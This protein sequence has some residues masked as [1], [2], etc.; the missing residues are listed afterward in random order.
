LVAALAGSVHA[1]VF[2]VAQD[3]RARVIDGERVLDMKSPA[4][5]CRAGLCVHGVGG[6]LMLVILW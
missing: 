4:R 6:P 5:Q 2:R 1:S 3:E